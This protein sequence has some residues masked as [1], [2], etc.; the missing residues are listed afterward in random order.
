MFHFMTWVESL[1]RAASLTGN[2]HWSEN[3]GIEPI[4]GKGF[5]KRNH[6]WSKNT[7]FEAPKDFPAPLGA[8]FVRILPGHDKTSV[9][10]NKTGERN[11]NV[12]ETQMILADIH[13]KSL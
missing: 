1:F 10:T 7:A 8:F 4:F 2:R 5:E 12:Q 6:F 9:K 13:A 11:A 3:N